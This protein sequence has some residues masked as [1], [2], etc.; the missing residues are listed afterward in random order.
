M[1]SR[2]IRMVLFATRLE[3]LNI[4]ES[5]SQSRIFRNEGTR[6]MFAIRNGMTKCLRPVSHNV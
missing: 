4:I 1:V 5:N 3:V 6:C 2:M